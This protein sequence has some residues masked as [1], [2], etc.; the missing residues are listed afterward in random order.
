[1]AKR[2]FLDNGN[3]LPLAFQRPSTIEKSAVD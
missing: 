1:M 2:V 3:R